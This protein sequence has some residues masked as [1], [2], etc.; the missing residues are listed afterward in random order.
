[1]VVGARGVIV[2]V[3]S[4]DE[5]QARDQDVRR[6]RV[7]HVRDPGLLDSQD[8]LALRPPIAGEGEADHRLD[9]FDVG[10]HRVR[11]HL[12][13]DVVAL[14]RN[15]DE[16]HSAEDRLGPDL[17]LLEFADLR[18]DPEDRDGHRHRHADGHR[19]L[20]RGEHAHG[21]EHGD[22]DG[23]EN[24]AREELER[25]AAGVGGKEVDF[26]CGGNGHGFSRC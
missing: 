2:F 22:H 23:R 1:M 4:G 8:R 20:N 11:R 25:P 12:S 7:V 3:G 18:R 17:V 16:E 19:E 24:A 5:E 15:E 26:C 13:A 21:Q 9:V 14:L 10:H 6:R